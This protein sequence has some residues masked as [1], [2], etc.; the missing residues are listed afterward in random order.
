MLK[1]CHSV[2]LKCMEGDHHFDVI[3]NTPCSELSIRF[4]TNPE[5]IQYSLTSILSRLIRRKL[6]RYKIRDQHQQCHPE[7]HQSVCQKIGEKFR[8][9]CTWKGGGGKG[10]AADA[11]Y[12][13]HLLFNT[14]TLS[15][16][17][18]PTSYNTTTSV[19]NCKIKDAFSCKAT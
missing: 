1:D 13:Q 9:I 2:Y 10:T 6:G 3:R 7:G 14:P 5:H 16:R 17:Y 12:W 11:E 15:L 18:L 8:Q 4:L 19:S